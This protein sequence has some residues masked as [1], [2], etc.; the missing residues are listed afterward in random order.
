MA[1]APTDTIYVYWWATL[2]VTKGHTVKIL[3]L[4]RTCSISAP[5]Y[6]EEAQKRCCVLCV[7]LYLL[8]SSFKQWPKG[9]YFIGLRCWLPHNVQKSQLFQTNIE[10]GFRMQHYTHTHATRKY[11]LAHTDT[12]VCIMCTWLREMCGTWFVVCGCL[13]AAET[14]LFTWPFSSCQRLW[15]ADRKTPVPTV[16]VQNLCGCSERV[17]S[18]KT[19]IFTGS[20]YC[21]VLK[22]YTCDLL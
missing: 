16:C 20:Q 14:W 6:A 11:T 5:K 15:Q 1:A 9:H 21:H 8:P 10:A 22:Y 3:N 7:W 12:H 19:S 13:W 2:L 17:F 4:W 18:V